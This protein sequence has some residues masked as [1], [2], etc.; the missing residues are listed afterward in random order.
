[1]RT[2]RL[3]TIA[4]CSVLLA[5]APQSLAQS[6]N[7]ALL[8]NQDLY[9]AYSGSTAYVHSDG[10]EYVAVGA[11]EGTSIV[12][13]TDPANPVEVGFIAGPTAG[14]REPQQYQNYLYVVGSA[15]GP[16]PGIQVISMADPDQPVLVNTVLTTQD[17]ENVTIDTARGY[18]YT[19]GSTP[20]SAGG[21]HIYS[22]ADP[23]N[24]IQ[25]ASYDTYQIH[26]LTVK[27]TRG[28]ACD[29]VLNQVHILDLTNPAIPIEL[30]VFT[31]AFGTA[32]T[33][34]P[35]A[36]D[37]HL[38][39]ADE[40]FVFFESDIMGRTLVYDIQNLSRISLVFSFDDVVEAIT[41]FP[42][43]LGNLLY[44]AHYTAGVHVYDIT[45]PLHPVK[46]AFYDT[47]PG[48]DNVFAGVYE[49]SPFPSGILTATDMGTG[50][51]V[52]GLDP[53][54]GLVRGTV[55]IG[56]KP[57]VGA[58][59][60]VLPNGPT[61]VSH[62]GGYYGLAP[63]SGAV[64]IEC[65]K[66]GHAPQTTTLTVA[67]GSQQTVDFTL[68]ALGTG[69]LK[70]TVRRAS[71]QAVL[72]G[73][74]VLLE[75]TPVA[76]LTTGMGKYTLS[77]V[78]TG[79][80]TLR[81]EALHLAPSFAAISLGAQ[82]TIQTNFSLE[83]PAFLDDGESDLGWTLSEPDDDAIAGRWV[84]AA[85]IGT[86][87]G[88]NTAQPSEDHSPAPGTFCFVTG[89]APSGSPPQ[90]ESLRG[91][92][93]TLTSPPLD[94]A[95]VPD[96]RISYWL[97][98]YN[99]HFLSAPFGSTLTTQ[100]SN[101]GGVSWTPVSTL[102]AA[103]R[104]WTKIEIR[105]M[106]YAPVPSS[107]V[108]IRFIAENRIT[109]TVEVLIDDFKVFAGPSGGSSVA[110][111]PLRL[112]APSAEALPFEIRSQP[113][114]VDRGTGAWAITLSKPA[115]V[116]TQLFDI[117]G[118]LVRTLSDGRLPAGDHL[119][120]WDGRV[121]GGSAAASGVYWLRVQAD[122]KQRSVKFVLAR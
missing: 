1:M 110:Q 79:S 54:Y 15:A 99:L 103:R 108:R 35:T 6:S 116:R 95:G 104:S 89:N 77:K 48:D 41:H 98:F 62:A 59:V 37:R 51:Y 2:Y 63:Q 34:I 72:A 50:L 113:R 44:V 73:A 31:S 24:P 84:R 74:D 82:S 40:N 121:A 94:L 42:I 53:N 100:L 119:L 18:L 85:P 16:G 46:V 71:D 3:A 88:G 9:S 21:L 101:D 75:G 64:T 19:S 107:T 78:P 7:I 97:W 90:T 120:R 55:R 23:V 67:T 49:A 96:P 17:A 27:G 102:T 91:G 36:D 109:G 20:S 66:F 38:I 122:Q 81:A 25:I 30:A 32:H 112:S 68:T 61:T 106:D 117:Q 11:R 56:N 93:T 28:Y 92:K 60:R 26:D 47:Y 33:A 5:A 13:L 8:A 87:D 114:L 14:I 76:T 29:Q 105:V 118:R 52:F 86:T 111:D 57:L 45:D 4:A 83:P 39:V 65:S 10:R 58:T 69:T 22:L 12:R 115:V 80:Y 43:V 70:G